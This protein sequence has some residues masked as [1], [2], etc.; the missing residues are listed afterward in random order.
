MSEKRIRVTEVSFDILDMLLRGRDDK[1]LSELGAE[2]FIVDDLEDAFFLPRG[3]D[4]SDLS[5]FYSW[6][7]KRTNGDTA[8]FD[9]IATH[10]IQYAFSDYGREVLERFM[11]KDA[12][13]LGA[14]ALEAA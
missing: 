5:L 11:K 6:F 12:R 1:S 2:V 10:P 13:L 8:S 9:Q 14:Q 3:D 7:N 4:R